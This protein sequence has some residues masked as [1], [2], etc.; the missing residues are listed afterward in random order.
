MRRVT[1]A[2]AAEQ[3]GVS[4][5]TVAADLKGA[6]IQLQHADGTEDAADA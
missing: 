2:D 6:S 1:H 5:T 3:L 4:P